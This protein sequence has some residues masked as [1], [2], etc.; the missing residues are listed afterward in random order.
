MH[1]SHDRRCSI[2]VSDLA[3]IFTVEGSNSIIN[4]L[5]ISAHLD[6]PLKRY[7]RYKYR[8]SII[9]GISFQ[10]LVFSE[11][12]FCQERQELEPRFFFPVDTVDYG[13]SFD[14]IK[15]GGVSVRNGEFSLLSKYES[16]VMIF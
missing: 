8:R 4:N 13:L 10:A 16:P 7:K 3:D 1:L 9:L 11:W 5:K 14:G 12:L 2:D 6:E 15:S